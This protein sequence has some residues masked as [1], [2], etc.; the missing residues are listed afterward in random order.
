M[1]DTNLHG[2][3]AV[4]KM[5]KI[6]KEVNVAMMCTT[7]PSGTI[8]S[9]PMGTAKVD[10]DGTIW[11]FTN[12]DSAKVK[13]IESKNGLC[14]CYSKPT[15]NT[16]ACIMGHAKAVNDKA[17]MEELWNPMLKAWFPK[18]TDDPQTTLIRVKPYHAEYWD[19][20]DSRMV[21]FFKIAKAAITGDGY[22][23]KDSHGNLNL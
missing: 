6:V 18:G 17:K 2:K 21:V 9:R 23:G 12:E 22:K 5:K 3:E 14:L 8:H 19:D 1:S 7:Q 16:Y 15:D 4:D 13:E 20:S 10:D 11:F